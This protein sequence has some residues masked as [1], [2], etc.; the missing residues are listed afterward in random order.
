MCIHICNYICVFY[1]C[2]YIYICTSIFTYIKM[3]TGPQ[4][5]ISVHDLIDIW[6][7][8]DGDDSH[9]AAKP[10]K[11]MEEQSRRNRAIYKAI[12]RRIHRKKKI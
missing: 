2:I 7:H 6:C 5:R 8:C 9:Y 4:A 12:Y 1:L 10:M 3:H 11:A